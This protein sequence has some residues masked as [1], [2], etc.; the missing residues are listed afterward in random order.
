MI[1]YYEENQIFKIHTK[2]TSYVFKVV[3]DKY[4][5]HLYY[6][7]RISDYDLEYLIDD[8][9]RSSCCYDKEIGNT[10]S[11][12]SSLQEYSFFGC[13]DNGVSAIKIRNSYGDDNTKLYYKDYKI[14]YNR[15]KIYNL[16]HATSNNDNMYLTIN[17]IDLATNILVELNYNVF[18]DSN[19]ISR[20]VVIK[21]QSEQKVTIKKAAS[22]CLDLYQDDYDVISLTGNY[23]L[24]RLIDR[25]KLHQG[26]F[27]FSSKRGISSHQ[28]NPFFA[29][30]KSDALDDYGDCYGFNFV[31]SGDFLNEIEKNQYGNIRINVGLNPATFEWELGSKEIFE[32]PEAIMTYSPNG[33]NAVSRNMHDFIKNNILPTNYSNKVKPIVVNTWEGSYFSI[34]EEKLLKYSVAAAKIGADIVVLDDGWFGRRNDDTDGLGDWIVNEKKFPNGL[35]VI[36]DSINKLGLG[37]GLWIE[38]EMVNPKS[39]LYLAHPDWIISSNNREPLYSRNQYILDLSRT[40]VCDYIIKSIDNLLSKLN[41]KYLKWDMNRPFSE[42]SNNVLSNKKELS[43]RYMLGLY[44]ILDFIK[45]KYP[46]MIIESCAGGGGRFDLGMLN[47][48]SYIWTSDNTSPFERCLIQDGTSLGYPLEVISAHVASG[49]NGGN[50]IETSLDFRYQVASSGMLG[51][52]FDLT[53]MSNDELDVLKEQIID[54]RKYQDILVNG[55]LYRILDPLVSRYY[56]FMSVLKDKSKAVVKIIQRYGFCNQKDLIVKLKGLDENKLYYNS[57]TNQTLTGRCYM[58]AGI[59]IP[60]LFGDAKAYTIILEAK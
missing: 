47:Y 27:S 38:P 21:N 28:I 46:E 32:T 20:N 19:V 26:L 43:H 30:T 11:L 17:L 9:I 34:N 1:K 13:G 35:K 24:E 39:D 22:L 56:S 23:A 4:L 31:Y 6:G 44:R 45:N 16:P 60:N 54:Y 53:K 7:K 14:G 5:I 49:I 33:I 37:F 15:A 12:D 48:T 51:Y 29:V 59:K 42:V 36:N 2:D 3:Y 8:N 57:L 41:V 55:E 10:F 25:N 18:Y 58:N 52:E 50:M 40:E